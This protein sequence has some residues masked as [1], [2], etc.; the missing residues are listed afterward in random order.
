ML[1]FRDRSNHDFCNYANGN[2]LER[3]FYDRQAM[4]YSKNQ[5][6]FLFQLSAEL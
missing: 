2:D 1:L 5:K 4:L 3:L 6:I